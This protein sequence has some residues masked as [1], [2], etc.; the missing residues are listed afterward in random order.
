MVENLNNDSIT[1][2][3]KP[4]DPKDPTM[5]SCEI[6][7]N[8]V[9]TNKGRVPDASL[10]TSLPDQPGA[11]AAKPSSDGP[12]D[13]E[14]G[15]YETVNVRR[16]QIDGQDFFKVLDPKG[17]PSSGVDEIPV[18]QKGPSDLKDTK[19]RFRRLKKCNDQRC[20]VS[21]PFAE[22]RD[23]PIKRDTTVEEG[24][25]TCTQPGRHTPVRAS[26]TDQTREGT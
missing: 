17:N 26:Q 3:C 22:N 11:D 14:H 8:P 20:S 24:G 4:L 5:L 9:L 15:E 18:V 25:K 2:R 13:G 6:I 23:I 19:D 1:L 21:R 16:I 10:K 12:S 7:P